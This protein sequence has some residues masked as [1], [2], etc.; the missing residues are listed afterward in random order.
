M[1]RTRSSSFGPSSH[2]A[3]SIK[4]DN[5]PSLAPEGVQLLRTIA[6]DGGTLPV[7]SLVPNVSFTSTNEVHRSLELQVSSFDGTVRVLVGGKEIH[8]SAFISG[9]LADKVI[10]DE[11]LQLLFSIF[12]STA[13]L[14]CDGLRDGTAWRS[15]TPIAEAVAPFE[16]AWKMRSQNRRGFRRK[17]KDDGAP[18]Q[19]RRHAADAY[20]SHDCLGVVD[21]S[22][23]TYLQSSTNSNSIT[24]SAAEVSPYAQ[25]LTVSQL[26]TSTLASIPQ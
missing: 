3:P 12:S 18:I 6:C 11:H 15:E 5:F 10:V 25:S 23:I 19:F 9:D 20:Y 17:K 13:K 22:S 16:D 14:P 7:L 8:P 2:V 24:Q 26:W 4:G 21:R 1:K